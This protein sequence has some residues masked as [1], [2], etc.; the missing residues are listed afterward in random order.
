MAV[1][2][3]RLLAVLKYMTPVIKGRISFTLLHKRAAIT[4]VIKVLISYLFIIL[5]LFQA[6]V[7]SAALKRMS[8]NYKLLSKRAFMECVKIIVPICTWILDLFKQN[9]SSGIM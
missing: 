7:S 6:A 5:P 4:Y 2:R 3:I 9:V 1:T 8:Y